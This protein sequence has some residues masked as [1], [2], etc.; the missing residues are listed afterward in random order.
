VVLDTS[1][2]LA[3]LLHEHEHE[4][5]SALVADAEDPLRYVRR[6]RGRSRAG[7][8][9]GDCFVYALAQVNNQPLLF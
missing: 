8:N 7:L 3:I 9:F 6:G 1:A 4:T 5:F 2:V